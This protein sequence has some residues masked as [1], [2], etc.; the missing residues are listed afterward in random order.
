MKHPEC[1]VMS[2]LLLHLLPTGTVLITRLFRKGQLCFVCRLPVIFCWQM[3]IYFCETIGFYSSCRIL[4][5]AY[6]Q[7]QD[8]TMEVTYTDVDYTV[9][10]DAARL[11]IF[12]YLFLLRI[13]FAVS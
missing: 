2:V 6:G 13:L 5:I 9:F 3:F 4:L 7:H 8:L 12:L 1:M 11:V 10:T